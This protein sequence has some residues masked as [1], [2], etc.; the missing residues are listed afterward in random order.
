VFVC[1]VPKAALT[2]YYLEQADPPGVP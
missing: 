1:A 2:A